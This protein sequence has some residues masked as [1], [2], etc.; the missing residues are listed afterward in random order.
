MKIGITLHPYGEKRPA[1]LGRAILEIVRSLLEADPKNEYTI[2][3]K[4]PSG[5]L[6]LPGANWKTGHLSLGV[7]RSLDVCIFNTPVIPWWY[8]IFGKAKKSIVIAYDFAYWHFGKNYFLWLYHAYSLWR[9]DHIVAISEATKQDLMKLFWVPEKKITVIYLGYKK[10]CELPPQDVP[11]IPEKF[12]LFIGA[13]K[14]RKNVFGIVRAFHQFTTRFSTDHMLVIAGNGSGPYVEKIKAYISEHGLSPRV[15]FLGHITDNNLSSLYQKAEALLYPS[16]IE[17]FGFPVLEAM[18]CG[19]PVITSNAYSLPE[20]AG[21][22]AV[23][24]DPHDIG[25]IAYI[26]RIIVQNP[27][28]REELIK[29]GHEQAQKFSWEK[30]AREYLAVISSI[31]HL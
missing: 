25:A 26:M 8:G 2:F 24:V 11:G 15:L 6:S 9:A 21:S 14:E 12:F 5:S 23:C 30:T 20:L 16:F 18:H 29:K 7:M 10:V 28:Y 22:A 31:L 4:D 19:L 1:G 3:L 13:I 27:A 17:G